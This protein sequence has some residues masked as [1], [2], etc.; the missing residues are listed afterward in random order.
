MKQNRHT[1][2]KLESIIG[3]LY[4]VASETGLK[5]IFWKKQ[6]VPVVKKP[7]G[8]LLKAC[9]EISEYL[10]GER[11]TFEVPL[12]I[13]GTDFQKKVWSELRKIPYGKTISYKE[14]AKRIKND[15]A[16]RAV[17][18]ANGRNPISIIIPCHRVIAHNG[19]MGG[20]AGGLGIKKKLLELELNSK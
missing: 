13:E 3:S 6:S 1:Q 7:E 19:T 17:G 20:Y 14:L 10:K 8:I 12:E 15:N 11:K 5:G 9:Q 18:T 4:V 16:V 2:F